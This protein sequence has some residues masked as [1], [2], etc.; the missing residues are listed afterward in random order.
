MGASRAP[1]VSVDKLFITQ[2]HGRSLYGAIPTNAAHNLNIEKGD[3]LSID[4]AIAGGTV[5]LDGPAIILTP[6]GDDHEQI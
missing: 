1:L 2:Q 3:A 4:Y 5:D 6:A